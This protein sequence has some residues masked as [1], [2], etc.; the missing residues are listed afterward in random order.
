MGDWKGFYR[1]KTVF[2]TGASSGIGAATARLL[3]ECG[4]SVALF[5]RRREE[6]DKVARDV[7]SAGGRALALAGDVADKASAEIAVRECREK[8]GSIDV[9]I[10]NAGM[11]GV[12]KIDKI[13]LDAIRRT[14]E[15]NFF[16]VVDFIR[17]L[18]PDM[19]ARGAGTIA[20]TSSIAR[21][22]GSPQH[23]SYSASK[24][25]LSN[26]LEALRIDST[27]RG[28]MVSA[29]EPGFVRTPMTA[30]N[31]FF[32]PWMWE[33]ERAAAFILRGIAAGDPVIRFPWQ[34][35]LISAAARN[36]PSALVTRVMQR[37]GPK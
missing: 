17:L 1:G 33:A 18:L 36:L 26:F 19:L 6:L 4:A 16:S 15:V 34:L 13:D 22:L 29:I 11:E 21:D 27:R 9:A 14:F 2:I 20:A 12:V 30:K 3:G 10:L 7:E 24:A 25:A 28:V 23:G 31:K 5:A 32:M 37:A 8:L 35:S